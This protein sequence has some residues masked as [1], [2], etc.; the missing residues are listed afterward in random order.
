MIARAASIDPG[1]TYPRGCALLDMFVVSG[2]FRLICDATWSRFCT[3]VV[4]AVPSLPEVNRKDS[5]LRLVGV[6]ART[7]LLQQAVVR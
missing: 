6:L 1:P 4:V 5:A 7:A 3:F 2:H